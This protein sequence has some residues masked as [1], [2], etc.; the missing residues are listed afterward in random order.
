MDATPISAPVMPEYR[1]VIPSCFDDLLYGVPCMIVV[2]EVGVERCAFSPDL[3]LE[4]SFDSE[5]H[6][7][8]CTVDQAMEVSHVE[9]VDECIGDDSSCSSMRRTTPWR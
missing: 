5:V 2:R 6:V 8:W 1:P 3:D 7:R 9:W 4:F